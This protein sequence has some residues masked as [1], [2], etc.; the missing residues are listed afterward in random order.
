MNI[1]F[2]VS[3]VIVFALHLAACLFGGYGAIPFLDVPFHLIGGF[4]IGL[5]LYGV[6]SFL[7][8]ER[9]LLGT[10]K[11]QQFIMVIGTVSFA[12]VCWEYFEFILDQTVRSGFQ[13]SLADTLKDFLMGQIGGAASFLIISRL[14]GI[15]PDNSDPN[16]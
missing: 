5:S 9:E 2:L 4:S 10:N 12:A 11:L 14:I 13:S 3:P 15:P 7:R 1:L 8:P 6:D 16:A